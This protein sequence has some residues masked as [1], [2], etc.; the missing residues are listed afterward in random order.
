MRRG[1]T[2]AAE[3]AAEEP[4]RPRRSQRPRRGTQAWA[5]WADEPE[6]AETLAAEYEIDERLRRELHVTLQDAMDKYAAELRIEWTAELLDAEF[7]LGD[8]TSVSWGDASREQHELRMAMHRRNAIAGAEGF[9]R[10]SQAIELLD[11]SGASSLRE[12]LSLLK[13]GTK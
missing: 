5:V 9:A 2:L 4:R 1:V 10:H 11:N 3:R 12:A 8:G 6:N 7:A 13:V